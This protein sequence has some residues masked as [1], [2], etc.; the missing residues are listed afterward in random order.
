L[1]VAATEGTVTPQTHSE[2]LMALS[3]LILDNRLLHQQLEDANNMMTFSSTTDTFL[4]SL[5]ERVEKAE[6]SAQKVRESW[7]MLAHVVKQVQDWH[8]GYQ[9][10]LPPEPEMQLVNILLGAPSF[11]LQED[12]SEIDNLS[13]P[14]HAVHFVDEADELEEKSRQEQLEA[15]NRL[16]ELPD[17]GDEEMPYNPS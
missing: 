3:E 15:L 2:E 11:L 4:A 6:L 16:A 1:A 17:R 14:S 8:D 9:Q 5:L 13:I 10:H 12:E 7:N